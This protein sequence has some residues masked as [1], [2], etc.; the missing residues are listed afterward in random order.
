[1]EATLRVLNELVDSGIIERYAIGG[2]IAALYYLEPFL[3]EDLDVFCL[4]PESASPLAPFAAV[5]DALRAQG[6]DFEGEHIVVEGVPVQLLPTTTALEL[7][8]LEAAVDRPYGQSV[9]ARVLRPEHLLAIGLQTGRDKDYARVATLLSQVEDINLTEIR[10]LIARH[11][12][13]E[14]L[15]IFRRRYEDT[16]KILDEVP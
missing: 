9:K 8:A 1:M 14:R 2:A 6:H 15:A 11:G 13:A 4:V 16:A 12:L 3:T 10:D 5:Y 7:E